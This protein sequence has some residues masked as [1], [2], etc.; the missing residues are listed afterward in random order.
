M[1]SGRAPLC[2]AGDGQLLWHP[3]PAGQAADAA[4]EV[5]ASNKGK[6]RKKKEESSNPKSF[7]LLKPGLKANENLQ[8]SCNV[9]GL[10]G[11]Q[12]PLSTSERHLTPI[13]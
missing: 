4:F 1:G 8:P 3:E 7:L 6:K 5:L 2:P 12:G 11:L 13:K 9:T 10:L